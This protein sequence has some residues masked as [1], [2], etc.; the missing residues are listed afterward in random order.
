MQVVTPEIRNFEE[1][2]GATQ[3]LQYR[4]QI[5]ASQNFR[6]LFMVAD[7]PGFRCFAEPLSGQPGGGTTAQ[8]ANPSSLPALLGKTFACIRSNSGVYR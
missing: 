7:Q 6:V 2:L 8:G 4:S 1:S 5:S 3:R